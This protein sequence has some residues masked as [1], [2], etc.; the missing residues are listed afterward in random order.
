MSTALRFLDILLAAALAG[1][2]G[3]PPIFVDVT[4]QAGIT[5]GHTGG[6][7]AK[8]TILDVNGSGVVPFGSDGS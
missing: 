5:F 1:A 8:D 6:F 3:S 7:L 4:A 2:P